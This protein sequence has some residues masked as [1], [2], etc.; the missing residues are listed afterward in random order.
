MKK[1]QSNP[2]F[3]E[4][5][6]IK[7]KESLEKNVFEPWWSSKNIFQGIIAG[8][9]TTFMLWA[10][11]YIS[12]QSQNINE[13]NIEQGVGKTDEQQQARVEP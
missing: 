1:V 4:L 10:I 8:L 12:D 3:E 13:T 11:E 2:E 6:D 9:I 7:V 5:V